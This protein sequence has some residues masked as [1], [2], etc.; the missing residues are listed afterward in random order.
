MAPLFHPEETMLQFTYKLKLTERV[1][2][3]A[4][5]IPATTP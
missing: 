3:S 5:A 1:R 2:P 4:V